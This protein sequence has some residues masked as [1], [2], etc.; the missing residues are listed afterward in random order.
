MNE[1]NEVRGDLLPPVLFLEEEQPD[2]HDDDDDEDLIVMPDLGP[3]V[4]TVER[5]METIEDAPAAVVAVTRTR[6]DMIR[7][8]EE[9]RQTIIR[10]RK[11]AQIEVRDSF[12]YN[13]SGIKSV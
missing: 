1:G 8:M 13:Y 7:D 4:C 3:A 11:E 2:P 12:P 5:K 6:E 9:R 10:L